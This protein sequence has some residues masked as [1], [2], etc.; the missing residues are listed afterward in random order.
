MIKVGLLRVLL[1]FMFEK[2]SNECINEIFR[3]NVTCLERNGVLVTERS[4]FCSLL[5]EVLPL[6]PPIHQAPLA[7]NL[8]PP[9]QKMLSHNLPHHLL[10]PLIYCL[11]LESLQ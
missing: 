1:C 7:N 3:T 2:E 10:P 8:P 9:L 6:V 11:L 5:G 4:N